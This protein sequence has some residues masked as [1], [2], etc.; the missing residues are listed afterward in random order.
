MWCPLRAEPMVDE[1]AA[2][3]EAIGRRS[4]RVPSDVNDRASLETLLAATVDAFGKVDIMVNCAGRTKH[5][6]TLDLDEAD[7]NASSRPISPARCARHRFSAG[8][9]WTAATAA[10]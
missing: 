9:W 2:D 10:S 6:P 5:V 3:I 1:A 7:W 4:L 8:T